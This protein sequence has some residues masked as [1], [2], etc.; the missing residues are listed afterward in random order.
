[1]CGNY[2]ATCFGFNLTL[3]GKPL[4]RTILQ[5]NL[6]HDSTIKKDRDSFS[7]LIILAQTALS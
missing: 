5:I 3:L 7:K 2:F 1:M 6:F 4:W